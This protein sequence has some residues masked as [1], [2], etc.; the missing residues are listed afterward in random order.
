VPGDLKP[1]N[2]NS[3]IY[4]DERL[5]DD[6]I[7][8]VRDRG[9]IEPLV[10]KEDGTIISGH[11]RW[12]AALAL[13]LNTVPVRLVEFQ[14]SFSEREAVITFNK[15]REKT[16]SQK[17]AEAEELEAIESERAKQRQA[18]STGGAEPQLKETFPEADKGQTRDKVADQVGLGS[19]KTY[20]KAKAIWNKAK[21]GDEEAIKLIDRIDSGTMTIHSA[22][23]KI[24]HKPAE[25]P[26][27]MPEGQFNVIYADP[28]WRYQFSETSMR[29]VENQYPT[30]DLEDIKGLDIPAAENAVLLLW[31]TAPKLEEALEVVNAWGFTYKTCAVW[32]KEKIGMGYWFRGQHELLL[33]GIK[34][35]FRAPDESNRFSSVIR[36][37]RSSHSKKPQEVYSMIESMFPQGK[38]LELFAREKRLGWGGWGNES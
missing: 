25:A 29:A 4:G 30:M 7:A 15:Q 22:H 28:P 21:Q 27:P 37:P 19:G 36:S 12:R 17:L 20:D 38:Y 9:I 23:K 8:S 14:N 13:G 2:I 3:R 6:F 10:I 34:G 24:N 11:R 35:S 33:L 16:V 1:H 32:D 5:P 26:P 18:T 31:A